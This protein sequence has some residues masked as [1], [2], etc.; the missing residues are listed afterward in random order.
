MTCLVQRASAVDH[1]TIR[2][3]T[4]RG[5]LDVLH[6][7][8]TRSGRSRPLDPAG[9]LDSADPVRGDL[10][11][12]RVPGEGRRAQRLAGVACRDGGSVTGALVLYGLGRW[13]G[14]DR[15]RRLA[16]HKW[17]ILASQGDIDR[18]E[19]LF[20]D[21]GGKIVLFGRMVP[22]I[23]SIVSVP[24]GVAA[25]PIPR[26]VMLTAIGSGIWNA[27]FIGLG[28]Y[29]Q[30]NYQVLDKWF[31]P[32]SYVALGLIAGGLGWLVVRRRSSDAQAST[33]PSR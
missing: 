18:G 10:A 15:L 14:N 3:L 11:A 6:R 28:W 13:L 7:R 16:R 21:H 12:R 33:K 17:F 23:R 4:I 30:E 27:V 8:P 32:V 5:R 22:V 2:V 31:G 29:L 24:A 20:R 9:E 1:R 25:M 19:R 26:F